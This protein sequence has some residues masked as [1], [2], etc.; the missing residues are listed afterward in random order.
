[1]T[2]QAAST[3]RRIE[4]DGRRYALFIVIT[5]IFKPDVSD[6]FFISSINDHLYRLKYCLLI[7]RKYV[8]FTSRS[9][10]GAANRTLIPWTGAFETFAGPRHSVGALH[11]V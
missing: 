9:Y 10:F 3:R 8:Y 1:M 11:A 5:D 4:L 2:L 7:F 6:S